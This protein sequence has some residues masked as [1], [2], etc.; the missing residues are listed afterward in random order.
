LSLHCSRAAC[1]PEWQFGG[2]FP[3]YLAKTLSF[4]AANLNLVAYALAVSRVTLRRQEAYLAAYE[5]VS[6]IKAP[7]LDAG[8]VASRL[9]RRFRRL[10]LSGDSCVDI[11]PSLERAINKL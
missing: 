5:A 4:F 10:D 11:L 8:E 1:Q 2:S 9:R 6:G 3:A 7:H